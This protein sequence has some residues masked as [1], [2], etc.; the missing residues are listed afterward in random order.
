M[1]AR[2]SVVLALVSLAG[3]A[4]LPLLGVD[5]YWIYTVTIGFYYA[6]LAG[7]WSLLVGYIG[8]ISFAQAALSGVGAYTSVLLANAFGLPLAL[9]LA[10][11]V[12]LAGLLGLFIGWLTLRL[13]GPYLGLTTIAFAEILRI[14]VT[15]EHQ[16][17]GGSRGL[18]APHLLEA[19]SR[20]EYY[21]LFLAALTL[22]LALMALLLRSRIGLF[23]QSIREDEDGAASLGVEVTR[24]KILATGISSAFAGLAGGLY[25]H[26]VDIIAP[27]MMSLHEMGYVLTMA[28]VGGFH[29]ILF[30]ALGGVLLQFALEFLRELGEWRLVIFGALAMLMLR[31]APNGLFGLL[32]ERLAAWRRR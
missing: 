26:Y 23:F 5:D 13:H 30:A 18:P 16:V 27:S 31:F 22:S 29:N 15:A 24:W 7:S 21:Y 3:F 9:T 2:P 20:I 28:V 12:A 32:F 14:G 17:T 4:V 10:C 8:R 1:S 11:G 6:L 19:G 25:A